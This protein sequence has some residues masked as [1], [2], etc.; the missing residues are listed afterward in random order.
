[1]KR[2]A[3]H[4]AQIRALFESLRRKQGRPRI[5]PPRPI[6]DEIIYCVLARFAPE[7]RVWAACSRLRQATDDLNELRVTPALE[8]V[9]LLGP[10]FIAPREAAEAVLRV[11]N[12]I[13]N[14]RHTVDLSFLESLPRK[15]ARSFLANLDGI[16]P[17]A[18]ALFMLRRHR[19]HEVPLD[20]VTLTWLQRNGLIEPTLS[21]AAA[22]E[23]L[24]RVV[25]AARAEEF[26]QVLKRHA[27]THPIRAAETVPAA[28][29]DGKQRPAPVPASAPAAPVKSTVA[30][31]ATESRSVPAAKP[32]PTRPSRRKERARKRAAP[33]RRARAR[34]RRRSGRVRRPA[35]RPAS[36]R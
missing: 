12:G 14:R 9:D 13:F 8:M 29:N 19:S 23:F 16:D 17:H 35:R 10:G 5:Q 15:E 11:L 26:Y 28:A 33:H 34:T 25:P 22:Q 7:H 32:K 18:L 36:R 24:I 2:P 4:P 6:A 20:G 1:M 3:G 30:A 21:H 27:W 31:R